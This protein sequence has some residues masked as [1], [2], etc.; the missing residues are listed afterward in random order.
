MHL[1]LVGSGTQEE[2]D[3]IFE[4]GEKYI[5][6]S[7]NQLSKPQISSNLPV[8]KVGMEMD[9]NVSLSRS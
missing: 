4:Q 3:D 8:L 6:Y 9:S 5:Y 1:S 2:E 7:E